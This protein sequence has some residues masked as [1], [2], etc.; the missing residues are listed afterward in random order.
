MVSMKR[1][2]DNEAMA[3]FDKKGKILY[4]NSPLASLL[5]YKVSA[6]AGICISTIM[7]QPYG[8]LHELWLKVSPSYAMIFILLNKG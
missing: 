7:E 3:V 1:L 6:L 5:G 8:Q 4:G 2:K